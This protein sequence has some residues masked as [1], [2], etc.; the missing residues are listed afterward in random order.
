MAHDS[1]WYEEYAS[2]GNAETDAHEDEA[3]AESNRMRAK[4]GQRT[5]KGDR[6]GGRQEKLR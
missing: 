5:K 1:H 2:N 6:R 3:E 4:L